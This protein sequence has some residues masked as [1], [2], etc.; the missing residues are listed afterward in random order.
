VQGLWWMIRSAT[1]GALAPLKK[2][3]KARIL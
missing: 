2:G 3:D 1:G